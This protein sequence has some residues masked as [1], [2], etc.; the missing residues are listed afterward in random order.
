MSEPPGAVG[1]PADA[2]DTVSRPAWEVPEKLAVV[3]LASVV[4]LAV[5]G[6]AAGVARIVVESEPFPGNQAVW[7]A[8]DLGAQWSNVFVATFLLGV[9]GLCWWQ[10]QAW[11][12]VIE[13]PDDAGQLLDAVG[14]TARALRTT[15]AGEAALGL[16]VVGSVAGFVG[17]VGTA[18]TSELWVLD[19]SSGAQMVAVV[20]IG[21]AGILVGRQLRG[22]YAGSVGDSTLDP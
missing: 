18:G 11:A 3:L 8:I 6:L 7:N 4:A 15:R 9:L 20:I 2:A 10:L 14:H 17:A 21:A 19:L 1:A 16:V 22:A 12:E 5:G 13:D